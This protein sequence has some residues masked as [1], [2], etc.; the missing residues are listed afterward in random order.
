MHLSGV[1]LFFFFKGRA[2]CSRPLRVIRL[3]VE[4]PPGSAPPDKTNNGG[5][6][7]SQ[8]CL[9]GVF[10]FAR[11]PPPLKAALQSCSAYLYGDQN[12]NKKKRNAPKSRSLIRSFERFVLTASTFVQN[13]EKRTSL[14][15]PREV[16]G[17]FCDTFFFSIY[18][19]RIQST[20]ATFCLATEMLSVCGD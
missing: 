3:I 14:N 16:Q 6:C 20:P 11:P 10:F 13:K 15:P 4:R 17:A 8:R 7:G 18:T 1:I 19:T 2:L 9:I 5:L 12:N